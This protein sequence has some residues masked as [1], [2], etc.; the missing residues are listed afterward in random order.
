MT[1]IQFLV[2]YNNKCYIS[3]KIKLIFEHFYLF[4]S[5]IVQHLVSTPA[6][7]HRERCITFHSLHAVMMCREF[8]SQGFSKQNI[9]GTQYALKTFEIEVTTVKPW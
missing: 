3:P 5:T 4:V 1:S 6:N 8:L 9:K 7:H 2:N